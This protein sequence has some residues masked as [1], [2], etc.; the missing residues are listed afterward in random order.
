MAA[1]K[2]GKRLPWSKDSEK[3]VSLISV[4]SVPFENEQN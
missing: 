3:K 4:L 1:K 2:N